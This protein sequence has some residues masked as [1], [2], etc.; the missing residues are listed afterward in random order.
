MREIPPN[1]SSPNMERKPIR[2]ISFRLLLAAL[3]P[4]IMSPMQPH[5]DEE[6]NKPALTSAQKIAK[7]KHD[8]QVVANAWKTV[9]IKKMPMEKVEERVTILREIESLLACVPP[10]PNQDPSIA[11]IALD[12]YIKSHPTGVFPKWGKNSSML[13]FLTLLRDELKC[14]V[15]SNQNLTGQI[16]IEDLYK[17][18]NLRIERL[19]KMLDTRVSIKELCKPLFELAKKH[20]SEIRT[21]S[22]YVLSGKVLPPELAKKIESWKSNH[23]IEHNKKALPTN[24]E[25]QAIIEKK[26]SEMVE[27]AG[28]AW[29]K[30]GLGSFLTNFVGKEKMEKW[31]KSRTEMFTVLSELAQMLV[32]DKTKEGQETFEALKRIAE[33]I[34]SFK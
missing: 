13:P 19:P 1:T 8:C 31:D 22:S 3:A 12:Q 28:S 5:R 27:S 33:S 34:S 24:K 14:R 15:D 17:T 21:I 2:E 20:Q 23:Q 16:A 7:H 32:K 30:C 9:R 10:N 18:L 26:V 6:G 11:C 29:L 4:L 25:L